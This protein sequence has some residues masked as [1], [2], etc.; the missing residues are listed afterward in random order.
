MDA[1]NS[2]NDDAGNRGAWALAIAAVVGIWAASHPYL[3]VVHDA[4]IYVLQALRDMAPDR[5]ADELIFQ[6][7]A[8]DDFSL[9]TVVLAPAIQAFGLPMA[10]LLLTALGQ[11][12]W[13]AGAIV[14]VRRL[15]P[16]LR[17][18]ATALVCLAALPNFYGGLGVFGFAESFLTPRIFAEAA[19]LWAFWFLVSGRPVVAVF[20]VIAGALMHPLYGLIG[21]GAVWIWALLIDW[22][23]IALA[24]LGVAVAA[25]A[26]IK[27]IAP[28]DGLLTVYDPA[29]LEVVRLRSPMLFIGEWT[30][31]DWARIGF[32]AALLAAAARVEA[33][34]WRRLAIT[35]LI[36]SGGGILATGIGADLLKNT[37]ALQ[38]QFYRADWLLAVFGHLALGLL[39]AKV[40]A[41][42]ANASLIVPLMVAGVIAVWVF[43]WQGLPFGLF[44]LWLAVG[45]VRRDWKP[46]PPAVAGIGIGALVV[47]GAVFLLARGFILNLEMTE[48]AE[49]AQHWTDALTPHGLAD[50]AVFAA[51]A[52]L[53]LAAFRRGHRLAVASLVGVACLASVFAW[54]RRPAFRQSVE[55]GAAPAGL[56]DRIPEDATVFYEGFSGRVWFLL[57]RKSYVGRLHGAPAT[58]YRSLALEFQ[59]RSDAV[60]R[61]STPNLPEFGAKLSGED[62]VY[63]EIDAADVIAT[64]RQAP[65]LDVML[66]RRHADGLGAESWDLWPDASGASRPPA[67][68]VAPP[69][70][71][72]FYDCNAIR[73]GQV[74]A[75]KSG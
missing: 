27:G 42:R 29:W 63:P 55:A 64:C 62:L 52:L 11:A 31:H 13:L 70:V 36:A 19:T 48:R 16:D 61:L 50:M 74:L 23:W 53:A 69:N 25:A 22:R 6:Y 12:L 1:S 8:Q 67:G 65:G 71:A 20:S 66:L 21:L 4:R 60:A 58:F 44:A 41:G 28:F 59:R 38:L 57:D 30:A 35:V 3:G 43:T 17:N 75:G 54:D 49:N 73:Q 14:L 15:L 51:L 68:A 7:G 10:G 72:Y 18:A 5:F 33:G 34:A 32:A 2:A 40:L 9:F 56:L 26:A 47:A 46:F 24:P 45:Q 39:I 37:L